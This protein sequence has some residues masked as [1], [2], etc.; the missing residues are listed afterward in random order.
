MLSSLFSRDPRANFAFELPADHFYQRN[1]IYLGNSFKKAEPNEKATCFWTS[2]NM[3][4]RTQAQKLKTLRHPN[5]ITFYDS[6]EIQ[7]TF[8]LVTE[9]CKPLS[10]YFEDTKLTPAQK[11]L[12][13]SWGLLQILNGLKFLH[14]E[15]KITQGSLREA[16]YV[17]ASG[18]W[19]LNAFHQTETFKSAKKDFNDLA[20]V[21]W[22]IFNGFNES[23]SD[24]R[25]VGRVPKRLHTLYKK[26][27]S[28]GQI[29][30][31]SDLLTE[32]RAVGGFMKNKFVDTLLFLEEFQLREPTEKQAFFM[33][34]KDNLDMFP[35]D[36]AKN[37]ILP[38]L[39]HTYE[40]GDAG[41]HTYE[42][43]DAGSHILIPMV[44]LGRLLDEEEYQHRIVPCLVKL[45][46]SPDRTTRVKLLEKIEEFAPHLKPQVLN[47]KIYA[48]LVTGFLDTN[49]AVRESTVKAMVLLAEKL[50]YNNLNVDL[51]KYL[52]RLQGGDDQPG[53]RTNTTI[54]LGKI[55]CY[56][57]PSQ[58]QKVL[59]SAFSR[60][61]KDPF[62][63]ARM[64][65]VLALGATQQF[66]TLNEVATKILPALSLLTVDPEKQVR[67]QGFKALKGFLEKLEK[68]SENPSIIPELEAQATESERISKVEETIKRT[69]S[70]QK[71]VADGWGDLDDDEEEQED[72]EAAWNSN[73]SSTD[74]TSVRAKSTEKSLQRNPTPTGWDIDD[75]ESTNDPDDWSTGWENPKPKAPTT[76]TVAAKKPILSSKAKGGGTLKLKGTAK[77]TMDDDLEAMLG[78]VQSPHESR[79]S[80]PSR[81][82]AS[83][84]EQVSS[85]G[86]DADFDVSGDTDN[87]GNSGNA[88]GGWDDGS[89]GATE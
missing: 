88:G 32:C 41:S 42:Y 6:L 39:I 45:F 53:I 46:S 83:K 17:T 40:Y 24:S 5:I 22:Q 3:Q 67:D 37:K 89:W 33:Q 44:K 84:V 23:V 38:K 1:G 25:E 19:K 62:P 4:L 9:P 59:I 70:S 31:A 73:T 68:A 48:N 43:G 61:L 8:Y 64:S 36:I 50:N 60:A 51:M 74:T 18:D 86:W 34:L 77:T 65:G 29:T 58:R 28:K 52:A 82:T 27:D 12:V 85:S 75:K 66:Y 54:C 71:A 80:T 81:P 15:V 30:A 79:G 47:D 11:E 55:G 20:V 57:D 14:N 87:F 76:T 7:D 21:I 26:L 63:P 78:T 13:V 56:I 69:E 49:P 2:S 72:E 35:D 16:I 10:A